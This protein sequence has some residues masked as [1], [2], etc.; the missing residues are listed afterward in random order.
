MIDAKSQIEEDLTRLLDQQK[1]ILRSL[2]DIKDIIEFRTVYQ[3]WDTQSLKIVQTLA[4]DKY[5]EFVNYY[6]TNPNQKLLDASIQDYVRG[7]GQAKDAYTDEL[8]FDPH[9]LARL[10]FLNQLQVLD[11]LS[12]RIETVLADVENHL[13]AELQDK[14]LEAAN[15]LKK[16]SLRAAGSL[17]G[18][19][20][21]RHLQRVA[22]NHSVTVPK[23]ET[24][25]RELNDPLKLGKAYDFS[26]WRKIQRLGDLR[27]LCS[28]QR[29]G[30][31]HERAGR[32]SHYRGKLHNQVGVLT[33]P[34]TALR[35]CEPGDDG[36]IPTKNN[37]RDTVPNNNRHIGRA[38]HSVRAAIVVWT[39]GGQPP[40]RRSGAL[41]RREGET[42]RLPRFVPIVSGN[43]YD[44]WRFVVEIWQ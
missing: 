14:E 17:A 2:E 39:G 35:P 32:R 38:R 3:R 21:E 33:R 6:S 19:V 43:W 5:D 16:I 41:A 12:Y 28:Y 27:N 15:A 18:V 31:P 10:R 40:S 30:D 44:S 8:P 11:E 20:L 13:F 9:E 7:M 36:T 1:Q 26:T 37:S 34:N 24:T 42:A 22:A 25:I 4:P 29:N 23:Q